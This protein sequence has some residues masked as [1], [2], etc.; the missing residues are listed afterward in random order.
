MYKNKKKH[1][2]TQ[3]TF[4]KKLFLLKTLKQSPRIEQPLLSVI[5]TTPSTSTQTKYRTKDTIKRLWS[6]RTL[7]RDHTGSPTHAASI[8]V[9]PALRELIIRTR[10]SQTRTRGSPTVD[11]WVL[12]FDLVAIDGG[13]VVRGVVGMCSVGWIVWFVFGI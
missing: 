3:K 7:A 9:S 10:A 2:H 12:R 4:L 5:P 6:D 11:V 1:P 8:Y 13:V